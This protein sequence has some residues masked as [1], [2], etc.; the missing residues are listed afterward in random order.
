[1]C[2]RRCGRRPCRRGSSRFALEW[3]RLRLVERKQG[4]RNGKRKRNQATKKTLRRCARFS[5]AAPEEFR[6]RWVERRM[7]TGILEKNEIQICIQ[8]ICGKLR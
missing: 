4:N 5:S 2:L 3:Q 1:M 6:N 7:A 8:V